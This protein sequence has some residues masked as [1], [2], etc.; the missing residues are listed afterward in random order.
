V[1]VTVKM[2]ITMNFHCTPD[3][4]RAFFGLPDVKPVQER[5]LKEMEERL[6]TN[7]KAMEPEEMLKTWL[8][9]FK[10]FEEFQEKFLLQIARAAGA[11]T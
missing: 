3:E 7:L 4:A 10:G 2:K 5:L 8:S 1:E 6:S 9:T 11:K